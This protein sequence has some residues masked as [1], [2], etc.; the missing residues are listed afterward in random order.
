MKQI[1]VL[2]RSLKQQ[3]YGQVKLFRYSILIKSKKNCHCSIYIIFVFVAK[4]LDLFNE[5][6]FYVFSKVK[7]IDFG[8]FFEW[9]N[10]RTN[11]VNNEMND[12]TYN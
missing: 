6:T 5:Q 8:N 1:C 3:G 7:S 9:I 2:W 4:R 12:V 11:K 10:E